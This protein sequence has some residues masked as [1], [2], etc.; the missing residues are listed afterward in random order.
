MYTYIQIYLCVLTLKLD[1]Q[2]RTLG[3]RSRFPVDKT[4]G[5]RERPELGDDR[6]LRMETDECRHKC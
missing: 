4:V 5:D 6:G 1:R 2:A 3:P